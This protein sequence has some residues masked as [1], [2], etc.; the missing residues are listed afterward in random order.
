MNSLTCVIVFCNEDIIFAI[1]KAMKETWIKEQQRQVKQLGDERNSIA[2]ERA[3][4]ETLQ[5]LK[6]DDNDTT[7][8]EVDTYCYSIQ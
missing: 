8:T 5:R 7:K 1:L 3:R 6:L 2:A 4:L